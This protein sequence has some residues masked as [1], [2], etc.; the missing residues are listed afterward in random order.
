MANSTQTAE[1]SVEE[2]MEVTGMNAKPAEDKAKPAEGKGK[3]KKETAQQAK[4]RLR[5]EAER[6]VLDRHKP[7]FYKVA[8]ELYEA[9]GF[10]FKRRLTDEE[11][12]EQAIEKM[13]RENP[14]LREKYAPSTVVVDAPKGG[15]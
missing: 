15:E 6:I 9:N 10:E 14:A 11:K 2:L 13:L 4:N 12:A 3:P 8:E 5:N 7:E 1:P